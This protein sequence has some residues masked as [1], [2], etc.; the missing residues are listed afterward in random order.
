MVTKIAGFVP[1][2]VTQLSPTV[3]SNARS[4]LKESNREL[5]LRV[6]VHVQL[7]SCVLLMEI[8]L[9]FPANTAATIVIV[10]LARKVT[11]A[12]EVRIMPF[13]LLAPANPATSRNLASLVW[14]G[15]SSPTPAR[16]PVSP[17]QKATSVQSHHRL[18]FHVGAYLSSVR[19]GLILSKQPQ[20]A[21][22]PFLPPTKQS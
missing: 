14:P 11:N 10:N 13:V 5:V 16:S 17:V 19:A 12:L 18:Q 8:H 2:V 21:A 6:A 15:N 22:T 1:Q 4:V 3:H 7:D 9:A 20:P